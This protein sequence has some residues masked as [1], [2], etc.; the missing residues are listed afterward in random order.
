MNELEWL[1]QYYLE[2]CN[3]DWEHSWGI[4]IDT[5]DNPG[6]CVKISLRDTTLE[7]VYFEEMSLERTEL[8]WI[9]CRVKD[10]NFEGHGGTGNLREI[11]QVFRD[12]VEKA[13][14]DMKND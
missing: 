8:D 9:M 7:T 14:Q 2:C 12:W 3:G 13:D 5:I 1:E 6:W 11:I 10:E 4:R